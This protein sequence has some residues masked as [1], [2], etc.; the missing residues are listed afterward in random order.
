ME[1]QIWNGGGRNPLLPPELYIPDGEAHPFENRLYVYG[2]QDV[3]GEY[4]SSET[5]CAVSTADMRSWTIH[6]KSFSGWDVPWATGARA[7]EV[8]PITDFD[9][10]NPT[11]QFAIALR[12]MQALLRKD[13]RFAHL[14]EEELKSFDFGQLTPPQKLLFAPDCVEADGRYYLYFCMADQTEGVAVSDSPAGPFEHAVQLPCAG[15]DPAVFRDED[16]SVYY[17]WGQFRA[18]GVKLNRDMI[19]FDAASVVHG[20][21]TEEEHGFHEGSSMRRRNG[22]YYYVYPCIYRNAR[23]TC[24]AYATSDSPL[25]PFTYRGMIIDN[26]KCDPQ[27]WNIH[28]SIQEFG[29]QWYVFYHRSSGNSRQF[30]RMCAEPIT[31]NE[32]GTINEVKMTSS[33]A[34]DPFT[35][36]EEIPAWRVCEVDGGAYVDGTDLIL[37]D[38]GSAVIR[39]V[40]WDAPA[41]TLLLDAEGGGR[42]EA[43][44]DEK[45]FREA[46]AGTHEVTL[47]CDGALTVHA[48]TFAG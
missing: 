30:R 7:R 12:D 3:C 29:G 19:S 24:L 28:G 33:G 40:R 43:F 9:A 41:G 46:G 39:Y 23:P 15:I 16:G 36:G 2:S 11:P 1:Q 32:D 20:I 37:P 45:P 25:G 38:G 8:Y 27:S 31:F 47:R 42:L 10:E 13:P 18:S 26:A 22:I 44:A 48:L 34:G 14:T 21:V 35:L 6:G 17:Y 4:Y 5:Y